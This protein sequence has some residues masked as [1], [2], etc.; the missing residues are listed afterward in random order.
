[1][2]FLWTFFIFFQTIIVAKK[3]DPYK[4]RIYVFINILF[5]IFLLLVAF[6]N[7]LKGFIFVGILL[8]L[9]FLL[10]LFIAF[11]LQFFSFMFSD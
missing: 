2:F 11:Y 5:S 4:K 7:A 9:L 10:N 3:N 8:I 1:M 6:I